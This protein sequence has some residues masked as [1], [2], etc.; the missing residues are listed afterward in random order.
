MR[1]TA[2]QC[3]GHSWFK[4]ESADIAALASAEI[5]SS[6]EV[7]QGTTPR[8]IGTIENL[9][10]RLKATFE[11]Y[12]GRSKFEKNVLLQV[13]SQLHTAQIGR[14][15]DIFAAADTNRNGT[16][17]KAEMLTILRKLGADVADAEAYVA[18]LDIDDNGT[19]EYTEFAAGCIGL[20]YESLR[21]LLWQSFCVLDVDGNGVLGR[22]E[23]TAVVTRTELQQY[24]FP[25][26]G[27]AV[28]E[29]L[30]HMDVD[31]NGQISFD[32]L[33]QH[34]LPPRPSLPSP[35][36][37][38][39]RTTKGEASS[40]DVLF[41]APSTA[42]PLS[43]E[44]ATLKDEDFAQLLDEIEA[45]R[46]ALT[47]PREESGIVQP[48]T[49]VAG[50]AN[51]VRHSSSSFPTPVDVYD[52]S[53]RFGFGASSTEP[54]SEMPLSLEVEP[55]DP[56]LHASAPIVETPVYRPSAAEVDEEL[57]NLL[58]DIADDP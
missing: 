49:E 16:L 25:G 15:G 6:A 24:G 30:S 44:V 21:G 47:A 55:E 20:L 33:C 52:V 51:D 27:A 19:V 35:S 57:E 26:G 53:D 42:A 5:T 14:I 37:N 29:V 46:D 22:D 39:P 17:D 3:L 50:S 2:Q 28:N 43:K 8:S 23:V 45:D 56:F 34:F 4:E 9:G 7:P 12:Q 41:S 1:P 18:C 10:D 36:S 13:A 58:A 48:H 38:S 31:K 40:A 11:T 54:F 32:E